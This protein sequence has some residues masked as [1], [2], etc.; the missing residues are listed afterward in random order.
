[1]AFAN[2]LLNLDYLVYSSHKSGT[3]TLVSTLNNSGFRCRH[4]HFLPNIDLKSGDLNAYLENYFQK[5]NKKLDVITVF[6]EP[7]ERHIS[8][9]FQGYGSRPLRLKG[10]ESEIETIIYKY[11]IDQLQEKYIAE[12]RSHS[13][14]GF[15][16]SMHDIAT[17]LQ[18]KTN[19]LIYDNEKKFGIFE[20]KRIRLFFFR[21][22]VLFNDLNGLLAKITQGD[23]II[24]NANMSEGKWYRDIYSKF[25]AS[26]VI[27]NDIVVEIYD[28]KR[29]LIN[30]FYSGE[31]MST[32]NEALIEY[33]E[34][35]R[36]G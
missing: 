11:T 21:F 24:K 13:L 23:I 18:I 6:R 35:H 19:D 2:E 10:V 16:E 3:Q 31:Y 36:I 12:L 4:C 34:K 32:L 9:F 1:M 25:K 7:M 15:R 5:N 33:G 8:S 20:T 29:D 17:E 28:L 27:P 22:D 30:L 14:I 26:L